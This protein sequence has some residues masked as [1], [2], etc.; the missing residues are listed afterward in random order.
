[1]LNRH[2]TI[3]S[4]PGAYEWHYYYLLS[5]QRALTIP[6]EQSLIGEHNWYDEGAAYFLS[7]Q[8]PEGSWRGG[9]QEDPIISTCF[10]ILFLKKAIP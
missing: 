8:Q 9:D 7:Q 5:M 4:N 6:P 10:A 2:Y 3:T 1:W